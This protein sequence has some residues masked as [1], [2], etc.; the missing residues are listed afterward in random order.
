MGTFEEVHVAWEAEL[1]KL[2]AGQWGVFSA[3]QAEAVGMPSSTR[4]RWSAAG[5]LSEVLPSVYRFDGGMAAWEQPLM[6]AVLWAGEPAV[7]SHESAGRLWGLDGVGKTA[8]TITVPLSKRVRSTLVKV[9]RSEFIPEP[10]RGYRGRLPMTNLA[11][12]LFDLAD[13]L[14]ETS[15]EIALGSAGRRTGDLL[16][17]MEREANGYAKGRRGMALVRKHLGSRAQPVVE[18]ALEVQV[19]RALRDARIFGA[20][21][22]QVTFSHDEMFIGRVDFRWA[23]EKVVLEADGWRFHGNRPAWE[24]DTQRRNQLLRDGWHVLTVTSESVGASRW[25]EQLRHALSV[26][27]GKPMPRE[28]LVLTPSG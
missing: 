10:P 21:V 15:Y 6:A 5:R 26:A 13:V 19:R 17:W 20:E 24:R 23:R 25:V 7:V 9:H 1:R 18:S 16:Q 27:R 12:T 3:R 8:P 11:R 14:D 4:S 28:V 2:A 22:Q